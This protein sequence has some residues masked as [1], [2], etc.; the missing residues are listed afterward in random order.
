M[1]SWHPEIVAVER[2]PF[3]SLDDRMIAARIDPATEPHE[4]WRRLRAAEGPRTTI[5]DLYELV[6]RR[7]GL[8]AHQLPLAERHELSS[9]VL[10][11][12][13]PGFTRTQHTERTDYQVELS[14]YDPSWPVSFGQWQARLCDVLGAAALRIEHVGSTSVP[15]LVAKPTVDIQVSVADLDDE[16]RYVPQIE[17]TGLQL[18]TR[19][20]LHRFFRPADAAPR[21]VHVHVCPAGSSWEREHLLF[22]DFLRAH[23]GARDAYVQVKQ[24]AAQF[25]RDDRIAYTDAKSVIILD[26]LSSARAW[27]DAAD[28][29]P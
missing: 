25:W 3:V 23:P 11:D 28:P 12:I 4:A 24:E 6:A 17:Q 27:A 21:A 18:R 20:D 19:D 13:W 14:G 10:P 5:I 9:S 29:T 15:G 1:G 2:S 7:R 8:A 16:S 22:R 26:L